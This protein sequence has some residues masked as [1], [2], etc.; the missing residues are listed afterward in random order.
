MTEM[1]TKE[2]GKARGDARLA[3]TTRMEGLC[4]ATFAIIITLLVIEIHRPNAAP[5]KLTEELLK[6]WTSYLAYAVAFV[7]VG[8]IWLNHHYLFARLRKVDL[9]LIWINL[10]ILGTAALIPF[11][12]GV[13]ASAFR[14]GNLMDQRGAVILYAVI[15]GMMSAAWL[16]VFLHLH[17]H[18]E[19]A[20]DEVPPNDFAPQLI[21]PALGILLY[22][23]AGVLGWFVHPAAAV[24]IFILI[25][26]YYAWTGQGIRAPAKI[27]RTTA[28]EVDPEA[29]RDGPQ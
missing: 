28:R 9:T 4:D 20:K 24:A 12:T 1:N 23:V 26:G 16:P 10:G 29:E 6:E 3:G 14:S 19:L 13:L 17:R 5:G 18:P 7:Y 15:A 21:R 27:L 25:V 8:V 2:C 11:P 22:V